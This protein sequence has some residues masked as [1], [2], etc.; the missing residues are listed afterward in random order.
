MVFKCFKIKT[1]RGNSNSDMISTSYTS[2][3]K[4]TVM[5][6]NHFFGHFDPLSRVYAVFHSLVL[7]F[8]HRRANPILVLLHRVAKNQGWNITKIVKMYLHIFFGKIEWKLDIFLGFFTRCRCISIPKND[9]YYTRFA[10]VGLF[11]PRYENRKS[12][13]R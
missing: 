2:N 4:L 12:L 7:S 13:S 8:F 1:I 5:T 10:L 3:R 11:E 9:W 6:R